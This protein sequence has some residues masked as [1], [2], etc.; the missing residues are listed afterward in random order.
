[1]V[2]LKEEFVIELLIKGLVVS[3]Y[4]GNISFINKQDIL[5]TR[6]LCTYEDEILNS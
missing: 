4:R 3:D 5:T 1:L 2:A 6:V